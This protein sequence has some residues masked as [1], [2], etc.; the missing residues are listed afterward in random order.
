MPREYFNEDLILNKKLKHEK[1]EL[2]MQVYGFR[3]ESMKLAYKLKE[4]NELLDEY[5]LVVDGRIRKNT[6]AYRVR[7]SSSAVVEEQRKALEEVEEEIHEKHRDYE[8]LKASKAK[9][10]R[11]YKAK[12]KE[13]EKQLQVKNAQFEEEIPRG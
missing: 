10:E 2:S 5:G 11:K 13:L 9:M 7:G 1:E 3:Q 8:S 6:K 4:R 12:I